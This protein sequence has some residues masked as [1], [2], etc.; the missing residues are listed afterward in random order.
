M[1][2]VYHWDIWNVA[3]GGGCGERV[4][5]ATGEIFKLATLARWQQNRTRFN[6]RQK[7]ETFY[8]PTKSKIAVAAVV[9]AAT[10]LLGTHSAFAR[11][12]LVPA[13]GGATNQPSIEQRMGNQQ[14]DPKLSGTWTPL[15]NGFPGQ[16]KNSQFGG[17]G[18][19]LLLTDGSVVMH[20]NCTA[21]WYRLVPDQFGGYIN[22]SWSGRLD[23]M[24]YGPLFFAS[25]VLPDG[26]L[27][28][29]G[30][31]FENSNDV[32]PGLRSM[33]DRRSR[34]GAAATGGRRLPAH[35]AGVAAGEPDRQR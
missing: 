22:G 35:V 29:N 12:Q 2:K 20:E 11:K 32:S 26:R 3:A 23:E 10:E 4:A 30:G 24:Q 31:E 1:G 27:I 33:A 28:V 9:V 17:P 7:K 18:T 34:N 19:A 25:A 21:N 8:V 16:V 6:L 5:N 13:T 14:V 15:N